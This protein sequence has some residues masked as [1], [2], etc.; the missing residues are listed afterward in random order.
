MEETNDIIQNEQTES[1]KVIINPDY[2]YMV[3]PAEYISIYHKLLVYL[4][5]FGIELIKDCQASCSAK[6]KTII[7]CW[8]M[9]Q[10]MIACYNTGQN[11]KAELIKKY[12]EAQLELYYKGTDKEIYNGTGIYPITKSGVKAEVSFTNP[13]KFYAIEE[14]PI[15]IIEDNIDTDYQETTKTIHIDTVGNW[16]LKVDESSEE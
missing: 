12:I 1:G 13:P 16:N 10:S 7:D 3:I 11:D 8:N 14:L 9:F 6:N 5:D 4:S 15:D 2:V